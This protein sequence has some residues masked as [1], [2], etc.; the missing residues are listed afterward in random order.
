MWLRAV[1]IWTSWALLPMVAVLAAKGSWLWPLYLASATV[2][3]LYHW[4]DERRYRVLDHVLAWA[5][6]AANVWLALHT[7][8]WRFVLSASFFILLAIERYFAA[9]EGDEWDYC[10]HHTVWHLWCGMGGLMLALGYGGDL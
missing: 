10:Q 1:C 2:A 8:D 6:I 7:V 3:F 5:S 4:H 9:H